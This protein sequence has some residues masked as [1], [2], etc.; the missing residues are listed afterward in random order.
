MVDIVETEAALD[1]KAALVRGTA[2]SSDRENL[3]VPHL[4]GQLATDAAIGTNAIDLA[5]M[6]R[7]RRTIVIDPRRRQKRAG[8][9]GLHAFAA[10][11][12]GAVAHRVVEI[13]DDL[14]IGAAQRH[15]DNVID[16]HLAAGANAEIALDAGIEMHRHRWVRAI[17][18]R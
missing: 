4:I 6:L 17:R 13:E 1:A 2:A 5:I 9:A 8:R 14:G 3:V 12:A 7:G 10:S 15:A 18:R 11:N 16:L